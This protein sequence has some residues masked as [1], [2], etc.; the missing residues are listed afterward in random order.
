MKKLELNQMENLEGGTK[1]ACML[2]GAMTV[3]AFALTGPVGGS[4]ALMYTTAECA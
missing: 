3:F 4:A 2:M 1:R